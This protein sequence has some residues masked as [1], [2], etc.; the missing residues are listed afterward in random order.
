MRVV[1][2]LP[3]EK[4]WRCDMPAAIKNIVAR[5]LTRMFAGRGDF[6]NLGAPVKETMAAFRALPWVEGIGLPAS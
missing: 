5:T 4:A 2:L 6:S 1:A 3:R